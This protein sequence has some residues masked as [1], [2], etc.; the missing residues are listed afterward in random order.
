MKKTMLLLA[1]GCFA[2]SANAQSLKDTQVPP[3]IKNSLEKL[4]PGAKVE[5]WEKEGNN[6]EA[7]FHSNKT[8]MSIVIGPNGQLIQ[9]EE[10]IAT[11][12]LPKAVNEY[13]TKNLNGKKVK[14]AAKITDAKGNVNYEAEIDGADF[15]FDAAGTFLKKE[16][17]KADTDK[18]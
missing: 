12:E 1:I 17:E 7:E 14:E 4:H 10:E 8:E 6:Y 3:V 13:V 16:V 18:K 2:F 15:I 11:T 9:T 5:K